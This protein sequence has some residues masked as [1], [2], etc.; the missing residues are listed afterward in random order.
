MGSTKT[1]QI[2]CHSMPNWGSYRQ[3]T[4]IGQFSQN[5][6][7][8]L[9]VRSEKVRGCTMGRTSSM[10]MQNLVEIGGR[11]GT[12]DE[13]QCCFLLVTLDVQERDPD[14]QQRIMSPFVE[15]FQCG[16]HCCSQTETS[17]PTVCRDFNYITWWRQ[18]FRRHRRKF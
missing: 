17:F 15:Q 6:S 5:F 2:L 18:N 13:K 3:K 4:A 10:R 7:Q 12:G 1:F 11:T 8:K 9:W 14:V 16:F